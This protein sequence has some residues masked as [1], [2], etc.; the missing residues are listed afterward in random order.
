MSVAASSV[1]TLLA[2]ALAPLLAAL[3]VAGCGLGAGPAPTGVQL[4]ITRD[5][6]ARLL[7]R[8]EDP[9]VS[10]QETDM[11]LLLRNDAVTTRYGGGF[12]ESIDGLSGGEEAGAPVDWFY[13][14]NGVEAPKGAADTDVQPGDH[15]WWDRHD[16]SQTEDVP[17]VVGS[18]PE[19][20]L[21]GIAGKRLPVRVECAPGAPCSTVLERLRAAGVPAAAGAIGGGGA[22]ESLRVLVGTFAQL[23]GE[24]AT[25]ALA[26]GPRASGIYARLASGGRSLVLLD[27]NGSETQMLAAGTGLVAATRSGDGA[28]VWL[29]A[30]TDSSGVM[31]AVSALGQRTLEDRFAVA[32]TPSGSIALPEANR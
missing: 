11:S 23:R 8:S 32:L 5:F 9:K 21:N 14:V 4:T 24:A 28:P 2:R 31:R 25:E 13:Y 19:P 7:R 30:G 29:V 3:A 6:G 1:R 16:W 27:Q 22:P 12:V 15:I 20:F 18:F 10:G 17:A 26:G